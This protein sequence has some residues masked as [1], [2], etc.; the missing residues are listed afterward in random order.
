RSRARVNGGIG[1]LARIVPG[2]S[3]ERSLAAIVSRAAQYIQYLE[4][5]EARMT[6]LM[7][8]ERLLRDDEIERLKAQ[9]KYY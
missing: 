8:L 5:N 6:E 4:E 7:T 9:L 2:G 1:Q 3:E